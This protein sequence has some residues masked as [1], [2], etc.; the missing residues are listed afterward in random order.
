MPENAEPENAEPERSQSEHTGL[1]EPAGAPRQ[2]SGNGDDSAEEQRGQA[3]AGQSAA[4][5]NTP[6]AKR[7]ADADTETSY[8]RTQEGHRVT[9]RTVSRREVT[10]ET[11]E[12]IT[13]TYPVPYQPP[14]PTGHPAPV[15]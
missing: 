6:L 3:D 10:E 8:Q 1:S 15:G 4:E 13:E 11:Q 14:S 5:P 12:T 2:R 9:R 7:G